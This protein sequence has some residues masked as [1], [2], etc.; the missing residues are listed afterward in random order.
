MAAITSYLQRYRA[1]EFEQVWQELVALGEAVRKEPLYSDTLAVAREMIWRVRYNLELLISRLQTVGYR[2]GDE[3]EWTTETHMEE[4]EEF[5][6][7]EP[8][9]PDPV[10]SP[11]RPDVAAELVE[12]HT[13]RGPAPISVMT[14]YQMGG[15]VNFTGYAPQQWWQTRSELGAPSSSMPPSQDDGSDEE[16]DV[17][18]EQLGDVRRLQ[19]KYVPMAGPA[20]PFHPDGGGHAH[21]VQL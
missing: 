6:L 4:D 9:Q 2:F 19:H 21:Q 13:L 10:F 17:R 14:W 3:L 1:G 15:S 8:W 12:L 11:P 7:A 20:Y 5:Y 16:R 18:D